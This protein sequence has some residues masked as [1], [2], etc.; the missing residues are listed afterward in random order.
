MERKKLKRNDPPA[1]I[2]GLDK[3]GPNFNNGH[4]ETPGEALVNPISSREMQ[5]PYGWMRLDLPA[6]EEFP[7]PRWHYI[8]SRNNGI[9]HRRVAVLQC[10]TQQEA[11]F[12]T[13]LLNQAH[14]RVAETCHLVRG[15]MGMAINGI[16]PDPKHYPKEKS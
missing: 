3:L 14:N 16:Q 12:F 1:G 7:E 11:I 9:G 6:D 10:Y 4:S 13:G 15:L 5:G 8:I 2:K